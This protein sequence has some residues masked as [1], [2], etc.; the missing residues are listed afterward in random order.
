M[1][2]LVMLSDQ[3]VEISEVSSRVSAG[4]GAPAPSQR[5]L[6]CWPHRIHPEL[7]L[8][9]LHLDNTIPYLYDSSLGLLHISCR[10]TKEVPLT[11]VR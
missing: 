11:V 7:P 4:H 10:F 5:S 8:P 3:T 9:H 6:A 1:Y 2:I